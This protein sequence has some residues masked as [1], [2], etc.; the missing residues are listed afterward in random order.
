MYDFDDIPEQWVLEEALR[1]H[2]KW[3]IDVY[4]LKSS[5]T[6]PAPVTGATPID[7]AE[8]SLVLCRL[9]RTQHEEVR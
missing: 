3:G 2:Y 8:D 7:F 4:V 6:T 5:G 9:N 1:L